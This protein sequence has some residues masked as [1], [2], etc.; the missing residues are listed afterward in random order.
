[1]AKKEVP[2]SVDMDGEDWDNA[3]FMSHLV[4]GDEDGGEEVDD[5]EAGDDDIEVDEEPVHKYR[6]FTHIVKN[7]DKIKPFL[8]Y[9]G[10]CQEADAVG[11]A[12]DMVASVH[13]AS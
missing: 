9:Q 5:D 12:L 6:Q 1:M 4:D 10:Y 11:S 3:N 7:L 8:E 2:V 13:V